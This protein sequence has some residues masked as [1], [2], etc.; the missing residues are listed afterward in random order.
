MSKY[1]KIGVVGSGAMGAG[2]AQIAAMSGCDVVITDQYEQSLIKARDNILF[3]L[4]K[5][6]ER[7]K[8][9]DEEVKAIFG[10]LHFT[11]GLSGFAD[12]ELIIE[13][14]VEDLAI[15]KEL[16]KSLE[17][18]IDSECILASNTSSLSIAS[19]A[20][21][22]THAERVLGLHFFNPAAL[23]PL[24]EVIPAIQTAPG[25][26]S[27]LAKEMRHWGKMPVIA[28]DTPGFIVNRIARPFYGESLRILE[29]S[30]ANASTIDYA[31]THL[32]GFR[33]GPFTLM[34]FIGHDINYAVTES[35]FKSFYYDPRYTPSF[36][37]LR[38]VEAGFLGRKS[39]KGFYTYHEDMEAKPEPTTDK[40]LLNK[41]FKRILVM[42]INEAAD[43]LY[44]NI[45]SRD[46]IEIAMTKGVNYPK[47]LLAW[48]DDLGIKDCVNFMDMLYDEYREDRYRCSPLLRKMEREGTTFFRQ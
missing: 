43:A 3:S 34:D 2:I 15:K 46:D 38:M 39:G 7:G 21:G 29:E 4:N 44:L 33:M 30:I 47:G 6:V 36:T 37:Q 19:L 41:I 16:F 9:G 24:V 45:A 23:M 40:N 18:L 20:S 27:E 31:M 12:R 22:C 35:V 5:F 17:S 8:I 1:S 10:R 26:T 48:A 42:L 14:I 13:A 11:Q 25:L 32:G 28:K